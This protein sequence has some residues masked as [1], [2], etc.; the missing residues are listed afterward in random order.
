MCAN[1]SELCFGE[2][3]SAPNTGCNATHDTTPHHAPCFSETV[4]LRDLSSTT[5]IKHTSTTHTWQ[6]CAVY[7]Y[8]YVFRFV[9]VSLKSCMPRDKSLNKKTI[10]RTSELLQCRSFR[11]HPNVWRKYAIAVLTHANIL[12]TAYMC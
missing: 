8:V 3:G 1:T 10:I 12:C 9:A 4:T 2:L 5:T 6:T 11:V 7:V